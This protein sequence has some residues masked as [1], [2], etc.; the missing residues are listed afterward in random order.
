MTTKQYNFHHDAG[1]GWL[2]VPY[3]TLL[4]LGIADQI[5]IY[6]YK[7][8]GF[9]YLEEDQDAGTFIKKSVTAG[10]T[11]TYVNQVKSAEDGAQSAM[12][13]GVMFSLAAIVMAIGSLSML[14]SL[15]V[16]VVT[17]DS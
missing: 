14:L 1:H 17:E 8:N 7:K 2:R 6:S 13:F 10:I 3:G 15:R 16:D 12:T 5:S 4:E 11:A 9:V